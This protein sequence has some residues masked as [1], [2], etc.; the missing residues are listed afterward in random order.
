M[1]V[2]NAIHGSTEYDLL[3]FRKVRFFTFGLSKKATSSYSRI[4]INLQK[5]RRTLFLPEITSN[6]LAPYLYL[7]L[8]ALGAIRFA[9]SASYRGACFLVTLLFIVSSTPQLHLPFFALTILLI[10]VIPQRTRQ[11]CALFSSLTMVSESKSDGQGS[12][13]LVI[14]LITVR[15]RSLWR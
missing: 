9:V 7:E 2:P 4:V 14:G 8:H 15:W 12:S 3:S 1:L 10:S 5:E 13:A 6:D 11:P